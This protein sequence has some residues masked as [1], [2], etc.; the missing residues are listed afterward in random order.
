VN[1]D[2][3]AVRIGRDVQGAVLIGPVRPTGYGG[4]HI[5]IRLTAPALSASGNIEVESWGGGGSETLADY[6]RDLAT[7]WRGWAEAKDW[8][9]DGATVR[10]SAT[11]D[12]IREVVLSVSVSNLP[13]ATTG[14]W[15]VETIVSVEPGELERIAEQ[16]ESLFRG[17]G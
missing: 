2:G 1:E 17:A 8:R 5:P 14:R 16:I 15:K 7:E 9:D 13:Y 3:D 11:H 12:G 4:L 6:F 10:M